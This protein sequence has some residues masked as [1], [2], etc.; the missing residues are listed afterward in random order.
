MSKVGPSGGKKVGSSDGKPR[1]SNAWVRLRKHLNRKGVVEVDMD[2]HRFKMLNMLRK[3]IQ[4]L[5]LNHK[6]LG[7]KRELAQE[8]YHHLF[9][10]ELETKSGRKFTF[11]SHSSAVFASLRQ[12]VSVTEDH[13]LNAIAPHDLPYMEFM[14]NSRSGQDFYLSNDQEY[15]LKTDKTHNIDIFK[16]FLSE[17]LDHFQLYPHSLIVKFLGVY[18]LEGPGFPK[19]HF[20]AMQNIFYPPQRIE[21][22]FD[23]KGCL[24]N[25]Y[26]KPNC[27]D[28]NILTILKDVNFLDETVDLGVQKAWFLRQLQIDADFLRQVGV[29]DYSLLIGRHK[30]SSSEVKDSVSDVFIRVKRSYAITGGLPKHTL[31]NLSADLPEES[32]RDNPQNSSSMQIEMAQRKTSYQGHKSIYTV[33]DFIKDPGNGSFQQTSNRRLLLNCKNPLHVINGSE[34]RYYLGIVDFF[35]QYECRQQLGRVLKTLKYRS[36]DHSTVP[37]DVYSERFVKFITEKTTGTV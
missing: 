8:D 23:I 2:H 5:M 25:R 15:I 24:K 33:P 12:A 1:R 18:S 28:K 22:R 13:Y 32:D 14:S 27:S 35:T 3:G 37:P 30:I 29:Q 20:L 9:I 21:T 4:D 10:K 16:S 19:T 31:E 34:Y 11:T 7:P 6:E 36:T 26:Q 17:Y